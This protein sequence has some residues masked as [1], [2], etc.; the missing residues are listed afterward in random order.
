MEEEKEDLLG[1]S[2]MVSLEIGGEDCCCQAWGNV[3]GS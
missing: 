2:E 1:A 3:S